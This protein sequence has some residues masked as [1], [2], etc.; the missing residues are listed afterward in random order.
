MLNYPVQSVMYDDDKIIIVCILCNSKV[1]R[2]R[3]G[4]V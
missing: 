3:K 1:K 2:K 4:N